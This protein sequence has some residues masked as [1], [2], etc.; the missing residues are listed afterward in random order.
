MDLQ[1]ELP[2]DNLFL[3]L[4]AVLAII[5]KS[6]FDRLNASFW[7]RPQIT[8]LPWFIWV[9]GRFFN[10]LTSNFVFVI[11]RISVQMTI[12]VRGQ[13][14]PFSGINPALSLASSVR[15]QLR[16]RIMGFKNC[17]PRCSQVKV[18]W[19]QSR[20]T[21]FITIIIRETVFYQI[22]SLI[23]LIFQVAVESETEKY[24][25]SDVKHNDNLKVAI[26]VTFT[27]PD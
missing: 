17:T 10:D 9:Y 27:I 2:D 16:S 22:C 14:Y 8:F 21:G 6:L 11:F 26:K 7:T 5:S 23:P 20:S 24:N 3:S 15:V 13:V 1:S 12:S 25:I 18:S 4:I 19:L